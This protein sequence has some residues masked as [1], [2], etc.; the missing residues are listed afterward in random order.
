MYPTPENHDENLR[1]LELSR[2]NICTTIIP[3]EYR[4]YSVWSSNPTLKSLDVY[5]KASFPSSFRRLTSKIPLA[6]SSVPHRLIK[7][8]CIL[9]TGKGI[10]ELT[11]ENIDWWRVDIGRASL[12][13]LYSFQGM[14]FISGRSVVKTFWYPFI[15]FVFKLWIHI[16]YWLKLKGV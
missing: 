4:C 16:V 2:T 11:W 9:G 1:R 15:L 7:K 10:V 12:R 8:S 6:L 14:N 3:D 5:Q 13:V